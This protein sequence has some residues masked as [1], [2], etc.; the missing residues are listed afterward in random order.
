MTVENK[1]E[2]TAD[3]PYRVLVFSVY[4]FCGVLFGALL[5]RELQQIDAN[6]AALA[7][8]RGS[9][10]FRLIELTR[11]WNAMH[12]GVYAPVTEATQPNPYLKHPRRDVVTQDGVAMTMINPAYMTR[13]I[14][15]IAERAEDVRFHIT[16]LNPI[17]PENRADPWETAAL[18]SFEQGIKERT[19][20][21]DA[22]PAPVHRFMAPLLVKQACLKCH[23]EQGYKLGQV[24]GGIS[25]T[26]PAQQL[27]AISQQQRQRLSWFYGLAFALFAG[28][29]HFAM[30]RS[31][32][33]IA[34]IRQINA[35]QEDLIN[36]RTGAL[37][38][39]NGS[40]E[41]EVTERRANEARLHQSEER[42]RAVVEFGTDGVYI[43]EGGTL[44]FVNQRLCEILG[45]PAQE[46]IGAD[47][48][49][50]IHPDDRAMVQ[51]RRARRMRGDPVSSQ[52][53][54]RM[55]HRDSR[56]LVVADFSLK[57][58]E[59][60]TAAPLRLLCNVRDVTAELAAE[61][62]AEISSAVFENAAEAIL[63]TD[64]ENRIVRVNPA[65]TA[66]TG[67]VPNDV[68][69]QDPKILKSGRNDAAFYEGMWQKLLATGRWQ[70][71]IWNRRK[72]GELFIEWL[73]I[74]HVERGAGEGNYVATFTDITQRK[75]AEEV[76]RH[77]AN[78]DALTNLP[79]RALFHDRLQ[80]GIASSR[81]YERKFALIYLDLDHFKEVN[82]TLGHPAGD[83][84]L[85]E[86]S[87]RLLACVRESD[88]VARLGG[89]EFAVLLP[90]VHDILQVEEAAQRA[91]DAL[92][93]PFNLAEGVAHVTGSLGI[94]MFPEHGS[95]AELIQR[96][97][98]LALY[99]AKE[100]GKNCYRVYSTLL[101]KN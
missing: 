72:N 73:S 37:A 55:Q 61:R 8:E 95:N 75:E 92:A 6:T 100:A 32:R 13:Q 10:L 91:L 70:G 22:T 59:A 85:I 2:S 29:V 54:V 44:V 53:R 51:E 1:P 96:H 60:D 46:L 93:R 23:A 4:V 43:S 64:A 83:T 7:R 57:M 62:E 88:T 28:L 5:L 50:M 36:E 26:M 47:G 90:E 35:H 48:L 101:N 31:R 82:D 67:F 38:M 98:D 74:T 27:L 77:K 69:G 81:R 16:S 21:V 65:F 42:Y 19:E 11:D 71:E 49:A 45:R 20:L 9:V 78:H 17:R 66:I 84:L 34:D 56:R 24:R 68:L 86:V 12:G 97:A 25:V 18:E 99:A 33:Y 41:K 89:D 39:A 80:S 87:R 76:I 30:A 52:Y 40:L 3:L 58:L 14:A 79:N 63:V 94:V 15:E